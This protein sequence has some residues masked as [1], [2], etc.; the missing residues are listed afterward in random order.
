MNEWRPEGE[1]CEETGRDGS[2]LLSPGM[3]EG[4]AGAQGRGWT[5]LRAGGASSAVLVTWKALGRKIH[6]AGHVVRWG[7][8][9][10]KTSGSD[11]SRRPG[12]QV[13]PRGAQ[14]L[15]AA[16]STRGHGAHPSFHPV[17]G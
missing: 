16:F 13:E 10:S 12:R 5:A 1:L 8:L 17:K 6:E 7:G 9:S 4:R 15:P 11:S 14:A 3:L 2:F